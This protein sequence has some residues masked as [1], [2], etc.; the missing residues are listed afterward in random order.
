MTAFPPSA[1][2]HRTWPGR[3]PAPSA[4]IC[5]TDDTMGGESSW[6]RPTDRLSARRAEGRARQSRFETRLA[7]WKRSRTLGG[8]P[9]GLH[10]ASRRGHSIVSRDADPDERTRQCP[11]P[12]GGPRP[13]PP[14][15]RVWQD[16]R[17]DLTKNAVPIRRRGERGSFLGPRANPFASAVASL[18]QGD[19]SVDRRGVQGSERPKPIG[20]SGFLVPRKWEAGVS[21][22][23][24][25][26][27]SRIPPVHPSR[28]A[29]VLARWNTP[30]RS[31]PVMEVSEDVRS[32]D[33][34]IQV[35]DES[36]VVEVTQRRQ[37][38]GDVGRG[39]EADVD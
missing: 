28:M 18:R 30:A 24:D 22:E 19:I 9:A 31:R 38:Q 21:P 34:Q 26:A 14:S 6:F 11:D 17:G 13:G 15:W 10:E 16:H 1:S 32:S 3:N 35:A 12:P 2:Y 37:A 25:S 23:I 27:R 36:G 5:A 29:P 33:D 4:S 39:A 7:G 20:I 8:G